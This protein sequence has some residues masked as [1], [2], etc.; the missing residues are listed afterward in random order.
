MGEEGLFTFEFPKEGSA[1]EP[2]ESLV[3]RVGEPEGRVQSLLHQVN[4]EGV[5]V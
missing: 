1:S 4:P 3:A 2:G 5:V